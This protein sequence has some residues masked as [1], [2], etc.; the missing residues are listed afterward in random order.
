M[1]YTGTVDENGMPY[2]FGRYGDN[3]YN[4]FYEGFQT[5]CFFDC[6]TGYV[7]GFYNEGSFITGVLDSN[8]NRIGLATET[9]SDGRKES[10]ICDGSSRNFY[11]GCR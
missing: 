4:Y 2:G 9:W 5:G 10:R 7:R 3:H 1:R 11:S 8:N 6:M